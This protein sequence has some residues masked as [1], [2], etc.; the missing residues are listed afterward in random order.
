V[1]G[2]KT[3]LFEVGGTLNLSADLDISDPWQ[4]GTTP[5]DL[6]D[7]VEDI[8]GPFTGTFADLAIENVVMT[9]VAGSATGDQATFA[10]GAAIRSGTWYLSTVSAGITRIDADFPVV[11]TEL[12]DL[13]PN[14]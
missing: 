8:S 14:P 5:P 1:P 2:R 4:P 11:F 10:A 6:L 3:I 13:T 7:T 12:D 9:Y